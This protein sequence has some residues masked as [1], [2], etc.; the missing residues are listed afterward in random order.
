MDTVTGEGFIEAAKGLL[1][2]NMGLQKGE[3]LLVIY[4][5]TTLRIGESIFEAGAELGARTVALRIQRM[6]KSGEEPFPV[7]TQA[8]AGSDV[9]IAATAASL[10]HTQAKKNACKAGAR[11]AT[12]PGITE[13]MFFKGPITAD[14]HEVEALT[15]RV[16]VV[17]DPAKTAE[18]RS[19]GGTSV[20]RMSL[21][22]RKGIVSSGV[23]RNKGESGNLPSG[24]SYIAPVE[25]SAEGDVVIDG[26]F[27][28]LGILASPL[29]LFFE[30]GLMVKAEGPDAEKLEKMLGDNPGARNL[31]E[32]GIGTNDKARVTGVILEDEKI[33]GTVHIALGSNDTFGGTVAAGIHVDGI[34]T[35]PEL[36]IDGKTIVNGGK[37]LI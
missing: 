1:Q 3:S 31:A 28:G 33:Y 9:V 8:M 15:K 11:I 16:T 17:L 18:L 10:T 29:K 37:V 19:G 34:I 6:A 4:D 13:D 22:G 14:Y 21:E 23:Y 27:V 2:N 25:G 7:V 26:S 20:L 12:M 35:R 36:L 5:E 32:L 30:K 24:E